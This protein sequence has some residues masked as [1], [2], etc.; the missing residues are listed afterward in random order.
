[1]YPQAR[2]GAGA[3]IIFTQASGSHFCSA[4]C[5]TYSAAADTE[6]V[7]THL[8]SA[9]ATY[10]LDTITGTPA[11]PVYTAG[12]SQTRPGGGWTQP[13]GNLLPQSAPNSGASACGVTPCGIE[14][15]DSQIRSAPVFRG[16]SIWYTQTIGASGG[17]LAH[18]AVQWTRLTTPGGAVVEGGRLEDATATATNGGKWYAY[19]HIAVNAGGDLLVGFSQFSSAQHPSAGYAMHLAGDG[20]GTLRD[21]LIYHAGE[22]YYHKTCST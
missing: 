16:G 5:V 2:A 4:P 20:A 19:P 15:Q 22:D 6:Y 13:S 11:A 12:G 3:G 8:N 10:T 17:G 1:N 18:T 14:T 21:A 9:G 7:V